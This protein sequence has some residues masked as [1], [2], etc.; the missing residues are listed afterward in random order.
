MYHWYAEP[1]TAILQS[2]VITL[3]HIHDVRATDSIAAMASLTKLIATTT[4][5]EPGSWIDTTTPPYPSGLYPPS[6]VSTTSPT[7][8]TPT[9]GPGAA[10]QHSNAGAATLQP[11]STDLLGTAIWVTGAVITA[12]LAVLL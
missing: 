7:S 11:F 4:F 10:S 6:T 9:A 5:P 8:S 3:N 1:S 12:A 2:T